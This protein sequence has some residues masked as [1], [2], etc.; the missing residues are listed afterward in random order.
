MNQ[1]RFSSFI[2]RHKTILL[3]IVAAFL[4]LAGLGDSGI[5]ILDEARNAQAAREMMDRHEWL[6]PTFNGELRPHKPPLHYYFMQLAYRTMGMNAWSARFFS[7]VFGWFTI[8]VTWFFCKRYLDISAANWSVVILLLSTHFLFEFRLAVPDPYLIFFISSGIFCFYAYV[9]ENKLSWLIGSAVAAGL[10]TLAKGPV[11][12]LLPG[13]IILWWLVLKRKYQVLFS[14]KTILYFLLIGITA[15]PWFIA[16]H[17]ATDGTFTT[18]FF[19]QHNLSRF[20]DAMEGHGGLFI[21]VPFFVLLG[22]LPFSIFIGEV[23]KKWRIYKDQSLLLLCMQTTIAFV[24]F[25]SISGT[26]LPNYPMP[27]YPFVALLSGYWISRQ[28]KEM[29]AKQYPF[30]VLLILTVLLT[31][32]AFIGLGIEPA[33]RPFTGWAT[34][35][36]VPVATALTGWLYLKRLGFKKSLFIIAGGYLLFNFLFLVLAYPAIYRNNPVAKT[37]HLLRKNEQVYAYKIYNP[38]YNFY[39]NKPIKVIDTA[40]ELGALLQQPGIIKI[41]SREAYLSELRHLPLKLIATERDLFETATTIILR[42]GK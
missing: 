7:A 6:I 39:L 33:T 13:I 30:V 42:S 19:F 1:T 38:A 2:D 21:I 8:R 28:T 29:A 24:V 37:Q 41:I 34:I 23:A 5:Y 26:K 10:A 36:L 3:F 11:A 15:L 18:E 16:I 22:L 35:F 40:E 31:T 32:A 27:V 25:F 9:T 14:W 20:G 17:Y 4:L 12:L